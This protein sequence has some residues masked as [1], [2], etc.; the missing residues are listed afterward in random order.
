MKS[1]DLSQEINAAFSEASLQ[2]LAEK[3][4]LSAEILKRVVAH[5]GPVLIASLMASAATSDRV[6]ALFSTIM[7]S[8]SNARIKDLLAGVCA[9]TASIKDFESVGESLLMRSTGRRIAISSDQVSNQTGIPSQ[10]AHVMTALVGG[11]LFGMLK[12]HILLEQGTSAGLPTLLGGQLAVVSRFVTDQVAES[13]GY[14]SAADF[15]GSIAGKLALGSVNIKQPVL[16]EEGVSQPSV[17]APSQDAVAAS[18]TRTHS[19]RIGV[20]LLFA[21]LS[22]VLIGVFAYSYLHQQATDTGPKAPLNGSQGPI[23]TPGIASAVPGG[24][25]QP[26]TASSVPSVASAP[27]MTAPASAT[28]ASAPMS[29][30]S[31]QPPA[32]PVASTPIKNGQLVFSVNQA[33]MPAL[34]GTLS[35]DAERGVLTD[36]LTRKFG[37]G[38]FA[39]DLV[40]DPDVR[41]AAWLSHLDALLPLMALPHAEV[42]IDGAHIELGGA[43]A[44]AALVWQQRLQNVFGPS[45]DIGQFNAER[46]VDHATQ[47]FLSAM[48]RM[49][50]S[51]ASCIGA[52]VTKVLNLQVVDFAQ[53]SGHIPSSAKENLAES[54][55]LLKA[56][57]DGGHPVTLDIEVFS[58]NAG[59]QQANLALSQKRADSVREFLIEAGVKPNLL[60]AKGFGAARPVA[61]N[62]TESGRFANRR[63]EFVLAQP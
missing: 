33:G 6:M 48:A 12:H 25:A 10:A 52:D 16:A 54:A 34:T 2:C 32:H 57:S 11:V 30:S 24:S 41:P 27:T 35:S 14:E 31:S 15:T 59:D 9:T 8:E 43:A 51:G 21:V 17:P 60:T 40:V 22:A 39:A 36:E 47:S 50:D 5:A 28:S 18:T 58:D 49:L 53:S 26:A 45:W 46:A 42:E 44:N 1:V 7:S 63:V 62:A 38:H 37:A 19:W 4:G 23:V 20:W 29:A 3:I 56:C 61:S 55:Q 13:I